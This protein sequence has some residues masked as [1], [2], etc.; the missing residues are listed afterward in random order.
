MPL[1]WEPGRN[2]YVFN[3]FGKLEV[4]PSANSV[5]IIQQAEKRASS[6]KSKK[7]ELCSVQLDEH[8]IIQAR[9]ALSE[10]KSRAEELLLVHPVPYHDRGGLNSKISQL[11]S[12]AVLPE[13]IERIP[14]HHP[15]AV[16]W[17]IPEPGK[18]ASSLP[19]WEEFGFAGPDDLE[20]LGLDIVFDC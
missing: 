13:R 2:P 10:P 14:L 8:A 9:M 7:I 11:K 16:F 12:Q 4:G 18:E 19:E 5:N 1:K 6:V 20:D 3:Y 15:L 17:F